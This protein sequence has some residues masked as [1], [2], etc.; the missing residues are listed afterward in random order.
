M[1][2]FMVNQWLSP[3]SSVLRPQLPPLKFKTQTFTFKTTWQP[4]F[5]FRV[6]FTIIFRSSRIQCYHHSLNRQTFLFQWLM[7]GLSYHKLIWFNRWQYRHPCYRN[8]RPRLLL[9]FLFPKRRWREQRTLVR[10][11]WRWMGLLGKVGY[12]ILE[13]SGLICKLK[14][15][16]SLNLAFYSK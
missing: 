4:K 5:K 8:S 16:K 3:L 2:K 11:M 10:R 15:K 1:L 12:K 9:M 14:V 7:M 13:K 6:L